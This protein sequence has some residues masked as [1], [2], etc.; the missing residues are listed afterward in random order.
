MRKLFF[1]LAMALALA[2]CGNKDKMAGEPSGFDV[3]LDKVNGT[4]V[5]LQVTPSNPNAYY[6]VGVLSSEN[7]N[8]DDTPL[9]LAQEQLGFMKTVYENTRTETSQNNFADMFCFRG[10]R[11]LK[12]SS[13]AEDRDHKL[14][15][16]QVDPKEQSLIGTPVAVP[17]HTRDIVPDPDLSFQISFQDGKLF[18]TPSDLEKTYYWE[19]EGTGLIDEEYISPDYYFYSVIDLYED[20]NFMPGMVNKGVVEWDFYTEDPDLEFGQELTLIVAGYAGEEINTELTVVRF[21]CHE[22]RKI[23]VL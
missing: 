20:Y 5:W 3:K 14:I 22:G 1:A 10:A 21:I 17:F 13:L 11:S 16:M 2:S 18:I 4:K 12:Y 23:E 19:Y 7:D 15:I 9:E 8:F 6:S